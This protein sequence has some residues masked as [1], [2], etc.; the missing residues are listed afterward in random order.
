M[1]PHPHILG[2]VLA[3]GRARRMGGGDKGLAEIAG[4]PMLAHVMERFSPQVGRLILNANGDHSRFGDFGVEVI[5][6]AAPPGP[7]GGDERGHGPL[8]GLLAAMMWA[9]TALPGVS[10]VATVSTDVPFL[11]LDL[12][13]RLE[14]NR[15]RNA[16]AVAHSADRLHPVIGL[17]PL[18]VRAEIET[19][20]LTGNRSM[21][22][23]AKSV[24]ATTVIFPP[25]SIGGYMIDPFFNANTPDELAEAHRLITG[26]P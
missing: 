14:R 3:G 6:D 13:A 22:A 16:A 1:T 4:R 5:A 21:Q 24:K 11:P 23:F 19:A 15:E 2:V 18:A 8:A 25:V 10:A 26:E 20:L 17:W 12:V 9:E 7:D